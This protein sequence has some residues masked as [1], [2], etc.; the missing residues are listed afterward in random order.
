[1]KYT[2]HLRTLRLLLALSL[3]A[4]LLWACENESITR[5]TRVVVTVQ[6]SKGKALEGQ[7]VTLYEPFY[8]YPSADDSCCCDTDVEVSYSTHTATTD[9]AG[10]VAFSGLEDG[11]GSVE[12]TIKD[13]AFLRLLMEDVKIVRG[14]SVSVLLKP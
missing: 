7:K 14:A 1:M 12:C 13:G 11:Y 3:L 9:S 5:N 8:S 6:N 10:K 2:Q 4:T